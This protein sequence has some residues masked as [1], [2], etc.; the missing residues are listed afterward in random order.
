MG[1]PRP[2]GRAARVG[3]RDRHLVIVPPEHAREP[4][5]E[6]RSR[7]ALFLLHS[8]STACAMFKPRDVVLR[9]SGR[10]A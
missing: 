2:C 7:I 6:H 4:K 1:L 8:F 5:T 10:A 3:G 9:L